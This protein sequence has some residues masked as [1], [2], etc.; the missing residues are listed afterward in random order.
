MKRAR[1]GWLALFGL[2]S[3][4]A[5]EFAWQWPLSLPR[6]GE[7]AYEVVLDESV[8]ASLA[9][10]LLRDMLVIDADGRPLPTTIRPPREEPEGEAVRQPVPWFVLPAGEGGSRPV[11]AEG[12]FESAGVAL[13]WK[14]P[15]AV[16]SAPPELLLD[17]GGNARTARA[18]L[19]EA[20]GDEPAWRARIEVLAS[21]DL[22]RWTP[23]ARPTAL[24]RL[25]QDGHQLSQLRIALDR[26]PERYLRLRHTADSPRGAISG[27]EVERREQPL[28]EREPLRWLRLQAES[29]GADGGWEY[30]TP[31][32]LRV[33]AW[34]I[35]AGEGNW[36]LRPKL[37]S[38]AD[39]SGSWQVRAE[40]E[41]YRWQI[42]GERVTSPAAPLPSLR[43]RYWRLELSSTREQPPALLL[44]YRPDR[45]LFLAE[46]DPP[47]RLAA[48]SGNVRRT[49][50]PTAAVLAA[51]RQQRGKDWQPLQ[52]TLGARESLAGEIALAPARTPIDWRNYLLWAVLIGVAGSVVVIALKLLRQP[53][54]GPGS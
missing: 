12:R 33:E 38:R 35:D 3:V 16:D 17:L 47:Y 6:S 52:V 41:A 23:V 9:D 49:D 42:D 46:V 48:G 45:L 40:A 24:Y 28:V 21:A 30:R 34:N 39:D 11:L 19:I 8:Y 10:P 1:M 2:G 51:I 5:Q 43:D 32:P 37:A 31:G 53:E 27:I 22:Q 18:L 13:S 7:P 26:A 20:A 4:H 50:A 36:V 15:Q 14:A 44:G 25:D 54:G 29:A